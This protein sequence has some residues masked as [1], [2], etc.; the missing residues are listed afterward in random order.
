MHCIL[1]S[2]LFRPLGRLALYLILFSTDHWPSLVHASLHN[3]IERWKINIA[4]FYP[5]KMPVMKGTL[6]CMYFHLVGLLN[7][8]KSGVNYSWSALHETTL[9]PC[10]GLLSLLM[11]HGCKYDYRRNIWRSKFFPTLAINN[12][13]QLGVGR[14][15]LWVSR[16]K[17]TSSP[18]LGDCWCGYSGVK[19][20]RWYEKMNR[21]GMERC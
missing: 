3:S 14:K 1:R 2:A 6:G 4:L 21:T 8:S 7:A 9:S 10:C 20:K 17:A 19:L 13:S 18:C 5:P 15:S 11:I 16:W 12:G